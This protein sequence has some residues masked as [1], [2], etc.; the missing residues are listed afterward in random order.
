MVYYMYLGEVVVLR[1][2]A[3]PDGVEQRLAGGLCDEALVVGLHGDQ[4][5]RGLAPVFHLADQQFLSLA[6]VLNVARVDDAYG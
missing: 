1:H 6:F 5:A 4:H 3:H 2:A